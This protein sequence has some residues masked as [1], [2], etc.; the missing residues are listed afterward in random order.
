MID[1]KAMAILD[2]IDDLF[3]FILWYSRATE[4]A[5]FF[6]AADIVGA[7]YNDRTSQRFIIESFLNTIYAE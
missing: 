1:E 2:R 5:A 3:A 7:M 6:L 4:A